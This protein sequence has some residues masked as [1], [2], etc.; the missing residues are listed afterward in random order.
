MKKS[1]VSVRIKC[2][3]CISLENFAVVRVY[4]K[5]KVKLFHL[6][7]EEVGAASD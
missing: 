4:C 1:V 7:P 6:I 2:C 5:V 3:I